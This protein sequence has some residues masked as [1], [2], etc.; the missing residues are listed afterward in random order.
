MKNHGGWIETII[1]EIFLCPILLN[2]DTFTKK[3]L[4]S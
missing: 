4:E 3:T 2:F 1:H